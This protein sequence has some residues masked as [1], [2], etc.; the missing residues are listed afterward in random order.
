[1]QLA[2]FRFLIMVLEA[3]AC[4]SDLTVSILGAILRNRMYV[5]LQGREEQAVVSRGHI[6]S[7]GVIRIRL[8]YSFALRAHLGCHVREHDLEK[9]LP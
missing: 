1:M 5:D 9:M 4:R 8:A 6:L 7:L 3:Q 2:A